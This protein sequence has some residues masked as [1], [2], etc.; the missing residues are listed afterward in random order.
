MTRQFQRLKGRPVAVVLAGL[1]TVLLLPAH[2]QSHDPRRSL[3]VFGGFGYL[4][5]SQQRWLTD[6]IQR[7]ADDRARFADEGHRLEARVA[8]DAR[9][10]LAARLKRWS[11]HRV[12]FDASDLKQ[13]FTDATGETIVSTREMFAEF[14][15]AY[16]IVLSSSFEHQAV[17]RT[18]LK[19]QVTYH[20]YAAV[21]VSAS[22][23]DIR[24]S[25]NI[26]QST[27]ALALHEVNQLPS[28]ETADSDVWATRFA[29]AYAA[30]AGR[31]LRQLLVLADRTDPG[32]AASWDSY[33]VTGA[34]V[35]S[36]PGAA[37]SA[38]R[39]AASLFDWQLSDSVGSFCAPVNHCVSGSKACGAMT[40]FLVNAVSSALS[41]AGHTV[42]PP[43]TWRA[44]AAT[45]E[46]IARYRLTLPATP[47]PE[48]ASST[49]LDF[50]PRRATYKV[51]ALLGGTTF[52]K[53]VE[54][55]G[56]QQTDVYGATVDAL[57]SRTDPATCESRRQDQH[58]LDK[59][60]VGTG[61]TTD[62]HPVNEP[63]LDLESQRFQ[64]LRAINDAV[65]RIATSLRGRR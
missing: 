59:H 64:Y 49:K 22:L 16:M 54:R 10:T 65:I 63:V 43:F 31:A 14:D 27:S 51:V 25:G 53:T 62:R 3:V 29:Q 35:P 55:L 52:A 36:L 12:V 45:T 19:T 44:T 46:Q 6:L 57:V 61:T 2:S 21:S 8:N 7:D 37:Q 50:D 32:G 42:L 33:M 34:V 47:L 5:G 28:R 23:V 13:A 58:L 24:S 11:A 41:Q 40:G 60:S 1:V 4:D 30:A 39:L 9:G 38:S 48:L 20:A 15:R 17:L 56:V 18:A 26:L